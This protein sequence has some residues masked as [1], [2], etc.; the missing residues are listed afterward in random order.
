MFEYQYFIICRD[1]NKVL[2]HVTLYPTVTTWETAYI[3]FMKL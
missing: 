1:L 2:R 3:K